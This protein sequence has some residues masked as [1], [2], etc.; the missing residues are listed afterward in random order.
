MMMRGATSPDFPLEGCA[1]RSLYGRITKR[2]LDIAFTI[3]LAPIWLPL[4][5]VMAAI[6][7]LDGSNPF[8]SQP[9]LGRGGRTFRMWKIRTMVPDADARLE[10]HLAGCADARNEWERTQKLKRDPRVTRVGRLLRRTSL[11]EL[12]QF[13]NVLSGEMSVVGPRP[14]MPSQRRAYP[15]SAYFRLRPGLTG[16][17]QV[18]ERNA[19]SFADRAIFDDR[20]ESDLS[21]FTDIALLVRTVR[22]VLR[23]TGC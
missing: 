8:Y 21:L 11:D 12:P 2:A 19:T 6:V 20:Y 1:R 18:S 9:R 10:A 16:P 14:M 22:A 3:A 4:V 7:A 5:I 15:G 13:A 17:W 23:G